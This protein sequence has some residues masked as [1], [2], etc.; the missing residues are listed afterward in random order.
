LICTLGVLGNLLKELL[1]PRTDAGVA[2]QWA[3]M[4]PF[5]LLVLWS[6]R[7]RPKDYR[8]FIAG[9]AMMNLAWFAVRAVH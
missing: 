6:T 7:R 9:L 2:V 3:V 1:L 5:W 4:V 8:I